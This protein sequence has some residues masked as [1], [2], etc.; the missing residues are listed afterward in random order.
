MAFR[1]RNAT[2]TFSQV[3]F[4][5][6]LLALTSVAIVGTTTSM[7][8]NASCFP[9]WGA[10][11]KGHAEQDVS[12]EEPSHV[13]VESLKKRAYVY[14]NDKGHVTHIVLVDHEWRDH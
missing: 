8:I 12:H 4:R 11:S 3:R 7:L 14:E 9:V 5:V 13:D 1:C 6:Q 2:K 10:D